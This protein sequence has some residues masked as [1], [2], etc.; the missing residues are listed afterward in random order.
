MRK[1]RVLHVKI[2]D[3][4]ETLKRMNHK[5]EFSIAFYDD[6]E[7]CVFPESRLTGRSIQVMLQNWHNHKSLSCTKPDC[8]T[9]TN[10]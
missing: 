1:M 4:P 2:E 7:Y 6:K 3:D 5:D 9:V 8:N 10:K